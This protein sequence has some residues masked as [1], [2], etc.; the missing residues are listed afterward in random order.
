MR[1]ATASIIHGISAARR[2]LA[3]AALMTLPLLGG[4]NNPCQ[5]LCV[6]ISDVSKRDCGLVFSASEIDQCIADYASGNLDQGM[7]KTCRDGKGTVADE[8]DCSE[9]EVYFSTGTTTTS[10]TG[11]DG[12]TDT[13]A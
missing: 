5:S 13:G 4:C 7:A 9:M 1:D 6:E 10:G 3:L 2:P 12:G 8:W 11:T